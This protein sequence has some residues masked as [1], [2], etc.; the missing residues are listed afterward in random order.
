[1]SSLTEHVAYRDAKASVVTHRR[2]QQAAEVAVIR[3]QQQARQNPAELAR[4]VAARDKAVA[5]VRWCQA[6]VI[7]CG[8]V[9]KGC[10][11]DEANGSRID[12][13]LAVIDEGIAT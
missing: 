2:F 4:L 11:F 1:M 5:D 3:Y 13:I 6:L 7:A 8:E 10:T 12:R 9:V